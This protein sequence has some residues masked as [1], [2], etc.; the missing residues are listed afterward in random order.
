MVVWCAAC[1]AGQSS[2][3]TA[4]LRTNNSW[5]TDANGR[6]MQLR[7]LNYRPTW[8]LIV[9]DPCAAVIAA[10]LTPHS[11]ADNFFPVDSSMFVRENGSMG[12]QLVVS[13]DRSQGGASLRDGQCMLMVGAASTPPS[14]SH[15][16]RCIGGCCWTTGGAW[17]RR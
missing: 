9:T 3:Y 11:V 2:L 13:T 1:C 4:D 6:E 5:Y 12:R 14:P 15:A 16:P 7:R 8:D 10:P 17:A